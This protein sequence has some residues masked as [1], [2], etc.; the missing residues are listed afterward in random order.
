MLVR[1]GRAE[2]ALL[3]RRELENSAEDKFGQ[4]LPYVGSFIK[5]IG[6][7]LSDNNPKVTLYILECYDV[8]LAHIPQVYQ[9]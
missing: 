2:G 7:L 8:L 9:L 6:E 1:N 5:Y 3:L 4:L